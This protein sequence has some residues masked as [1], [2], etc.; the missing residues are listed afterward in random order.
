VCQLAKEYILLWSYT[1]TKFMTLKGLTHLMVLFTIPDTKASI[2]NTQQT[3]SH[4]KQTITFH[5]TNYFT[6]EQVR[7]LGVGT[8]SFTFQRNKLYSVISSIICFFNNNSKSYLPHFVS[9]SS[10]QLES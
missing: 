10:Q 6:L 9:N 2:V 1:S 4:S 3:T 7:I 5:Y 8:S